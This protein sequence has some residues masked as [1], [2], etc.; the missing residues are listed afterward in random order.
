LAMGTDRMATLPIVVS[1][2]KR[3][4]ANALPIDYMVTM[5]GLEGYPVFGTVATTGTNLLRM[6]QR[7]LR[8]TLVFKV[9]I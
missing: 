6:F 2:N 3:D 7:I 9:G 1:L 5:M 8:D 4:V